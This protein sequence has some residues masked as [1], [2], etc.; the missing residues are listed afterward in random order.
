MVTI[1]RFIIGLTQV[2]AGIVSLSFSGWQYQNDSGGISITYIST[3]GSVSVKSLSDI[4]T[5][6]PYEYLRRKY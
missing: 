6:F 4:C 3:S 5:L 2:I 1:S